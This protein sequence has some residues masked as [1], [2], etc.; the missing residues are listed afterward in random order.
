MTLTTHAL[1]GAAAASLF[2]QKPVLAFAAGFV[3]HFCI[4]AIP[5]WD[6]RPESMI[7]DK[8]NKLA[9]DMILGKSFFKDLIFIGSDALLGL[10]LSVL[11][12]SLW[13][14]H[15]P[16]AIITLGVIAAI[17]PDPL[18]FIYYKTHSKLLEPLQKFHAVWLQQKSPINVPAWIG[19]GLQALLVATVVGILKIIHPVL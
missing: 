17:L 14:F 10:A 9:T 2:S 4:D 5:H 1:V 19:L 16:I 3:S 6:Y 15:V 11:I 8:N 12:F 7:K 18:Q 13:L